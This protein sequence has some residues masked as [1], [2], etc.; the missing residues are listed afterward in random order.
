MTKSTPEWKTWLSTVERGYVHSI[1]VKPDVKA[2][3]LLFLLI[4]DVQ[5]SMKNVKYM[6]CVHL[7]PFLAKNHES[8]LTFCSTVKT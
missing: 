8:G 1:F 6:I 3:C 5:A 4:T 2:K 7:N